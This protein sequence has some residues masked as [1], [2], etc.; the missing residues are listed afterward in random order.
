MSETLV[1]HQEYKRRNNCTK[2]DNSTTEQLAIFIC[3][4]RVNINTADSLYN[5]IIRDPKLNKIRIK[6]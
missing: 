3:I 2:C 4:S 1:L 6:N 5:I